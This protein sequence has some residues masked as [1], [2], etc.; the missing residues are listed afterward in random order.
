MLP[1]KSPYAEQDREGDA[2]GDREN[3]DEEERGWERWVGRMHRRRRV[4]VF[5][6]AVLCWAL[7]CHWRSVLRTISTLPLP[8][9]LRLNGKDSSSPVVGS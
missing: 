7:G 9:S 6:S 1:R 4:H 3:A 8:L 5:M 2:D